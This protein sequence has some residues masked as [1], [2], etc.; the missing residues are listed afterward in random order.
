[1]FF[2]GALLGAASVASIV[3]P[4]QYCTAP[5]KYVTINENSTD[6]NFSDYVTTD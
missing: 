5:V 3:L 4:L 2:G 1:M 6:Y